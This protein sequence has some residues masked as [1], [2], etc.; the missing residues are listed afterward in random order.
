[1]NNNFSQLS[2]SELED[3]NGGGIMEDL[4]K[5]VGYGVGYVGQGVVEGVKGIGSAVKE[6]VNPWNYINYATNGRR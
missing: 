5:A 2:M 1:M 3:I 4:G 6:F